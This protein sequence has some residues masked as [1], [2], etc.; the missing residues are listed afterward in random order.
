[1]DSE[2]QTYYQTGLKDA[3]AILFYAVGW[4]TIHAILQEYVLDKLQRKLHLSY[5][6]HDLRLHLDLTKLWIGYPEVHHCLL[7]ASVP[8]ILF[9]KSA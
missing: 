4:I 9:P 5:I 7:V 2:P 1:L 3:A 6:M 8:G